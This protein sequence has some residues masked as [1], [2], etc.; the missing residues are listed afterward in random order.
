MVGG[1]IRLESFGRKGRKKLAKSHRNPLAS[2]M[3]FC[4]IAN[5]V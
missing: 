5:C 4:I 1:P 3:H 2:S